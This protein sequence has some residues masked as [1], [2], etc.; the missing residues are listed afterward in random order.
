MTEQPKFDPVKEFVSLRDNLSRAVGESLRAATGTTFPAIDM[1][2]TDDAVIIYTEPLLGA[3]PSKFEVSMEDDM[4]VISGET[5]AHIQID[6]SAYLQRELRF[7]A[8]A[9]TIRIPR[10]VKATEA[11]ATFKKSVLTIT[12]PKQTDSGSQIIGV[13]PAE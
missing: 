8:F 11:R 3:D 13:T 5:Q 7:G 4:L 6:D 12:I 1:Y 9:R 2:E 10:K